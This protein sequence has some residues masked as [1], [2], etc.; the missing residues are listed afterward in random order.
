MQLLRLLLLRLLF[1]AC[2][3][4]IVSGW[5]GINAEDTEV[6]LPPL[7][8]HLLPPTLAQ[9]QDER[10]KGDYFTEIKP[11]PV[12]YLIWSEL[13]IKVYLDRPLNLEDTAASTQ[14]FQQWVAAVRQGI[15]EWNAYLPL[16]EVEQP[17]LADI[18]IERSSP[19]IGSQID[20]ATGQL[21]IPRARSAQTRYQFYLQASN[22]PI[23]RHRMTVQ[24]NPGLSAQSILS[25]TR[26]ELGH[27]LGIWGH[28]PVATDA[29][30]FSQVRNSPS[31]S[32][33]DVNTLKK[34]YQQ[35]TRLGWAVR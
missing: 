20:P 18:A 4:L 23:L 16:Q 34:L 22:P 1:A 5:L 11:S 7:Q 6:S 27:A 17:E 28:S 33:R 29:L 30:Y 12:G 32:A 31:I 25:A 24:I 26:H 19:P 3:L 21:E 2:L 13:P 8:A 14:R 15:A 10:E 35:P 9:W